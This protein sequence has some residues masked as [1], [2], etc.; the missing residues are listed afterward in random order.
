M[1]CPCRE[2]VLLA[3]CQNKRKLRCD[4]LIAVFKELGG[5]QIEGPKSLLWKDLNIVL[6]KLVEVNKET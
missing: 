6:P 5:P 3:M 2:C 4:K 1:K